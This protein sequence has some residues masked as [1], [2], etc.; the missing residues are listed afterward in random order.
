RQLRGD[1]GQRPGFASWSV[2][3]ADDR[4]GTRDSLP[5]VAP[6]LN[7]TRLVFHRQDAKSAK[8]AKRMRG[9]A[10]APRHQARRNAS[11]RSL[12]LPSLGVLGVLGALAVGCGDFGGCGLVSDGEASYLRSPAFTL[13]SFSGWKYLWITRST[14][15]GVSA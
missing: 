8:L 5:E 2:L 15:D 4:I 12:L 7:S 3:A 10:A 14:S 11:D 6:Y 13:N 1:P 9:K